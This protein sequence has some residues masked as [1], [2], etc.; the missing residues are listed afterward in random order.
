[1]TQ[2]RETKKKTIQQ[3][4]QLPFEKKAMGLERGLSG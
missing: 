3:H 1:M 4:T 2:R